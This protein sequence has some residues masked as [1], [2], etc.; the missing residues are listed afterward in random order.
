MK[1]IY[2]I[3]KIKGKEN[4]THRHFIFPNTFL[5]PVNGSK[6]SILNWVIKLNLFM[7]FFSFLFLKHPWKIFHSIL[8]FTLLFGLNTIERPIK[9]SYMYLSSQLF[10]KTPHRTLK[11]Q[12]ESKK[13]HFPRI[14]RPKLKKFSLQC[15]PWGHPHRATELSKQ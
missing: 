5:Q 4:S 6:N 13:M 11:F 10:F 3:Q 9:E 1:L 14:W 7:S 15:L 8:L 12:E 2:Y